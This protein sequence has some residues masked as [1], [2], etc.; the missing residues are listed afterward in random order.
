MTKR[1]AKQ[2][3]RQAAKLAP[4]RQNRHG[5][6]QNGDIAATGV[7]LPPT[8]ISCFLKLMAAA[9]VSWGEGGE[10]GL[11]LRLHQHVTR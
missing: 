3:K 7:R 6:R 10:D 9:Q 11:V 1:E 8:L 5:T 4:Q 2:I